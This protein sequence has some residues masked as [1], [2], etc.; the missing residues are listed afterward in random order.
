MSAHDTSTDG[1][2][3]RRRPGPK[4]RPGEPS[5]P[6]EVR[7]AVVEAATRLFARHGV[8][9]VTLRM[10]AAEAGVNPGLIGRYIGRR[11]ELIDEVYRHLTHVLAT[12]LDESP[13]RPRSF[14]RESA[15]GAWTVLMTY[16]AVR[17]LVPPTDAANPVEELAT[18]IRALYG[19]DERDARWRAAQILGSALGW[20]LYERLLVEL[21][22]IAPTELAELREDLFL[23]HHLV[24]SHRLPTPRPHPENEP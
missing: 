11:A 5:G 14:E 10:I 22:G 21:A 23:V 4:R 16:Y 8:D 13:M 19:L 3:T 1:P 20:R 12:E 7:R 17:E 2:S 18:T 24:A 15:M 6:D 9:A